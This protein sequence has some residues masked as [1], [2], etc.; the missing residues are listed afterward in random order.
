MSIEDEILKTFEM[1]KSREICQQNKICV[2]CKK[3]AEYFKD[4]L[5]LKEYSI[6]GLCQECQD[7]IFKE[8]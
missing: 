2:L 5:S 3:P 1:L 8:S 4:S 6:S 7:K